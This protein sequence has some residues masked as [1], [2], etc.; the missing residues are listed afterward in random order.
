M[1]HFNKIVEAFLYVSSEQ[2]LMHSAV[3]NKTTGEI[4]YRSELTDQDEF[5]EDV[6]SG[7]YIVIPHKHDLELGTDLV[8][9]FVGRYLPDKLAEVDQIFARRGA[10]GHFKSLLKSEKKLEEWYEFED[11][12]TREA[13]WQWCQENGL[14][15]DD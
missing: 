8:F 4:F 5:P 11:E 10:Y 14:E 1:I 9:D 15:I 3:L 2:P 7:D 6:D 12:Q 13:L